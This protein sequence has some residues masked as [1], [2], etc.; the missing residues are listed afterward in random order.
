MS[1]AHLSGL[2][3]GLYFASRGMLVL[4]TVMTEE[5]VANISERFDAVMADVAH[6]LETTTA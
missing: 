3:H 2:N 5:D 6:N 1:L 4:S